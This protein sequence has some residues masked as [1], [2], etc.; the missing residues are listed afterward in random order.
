MCMADTSTMPSRILAS[1]TAVSTSAVM[2]MYSRF[3]WVSKVRYLVWA[4]MYCSRVPKG[5]VAARNLP[6]AGTPLKC[7]RSADW[8]TIRHNFSGAYMTQR[9]SVSGLFVLFAFC[10]LAAAQSPNWEIKDEALRT[11]FQA[12]V[13]A[14]ADRTSAE[15]RSITDWNA[16]RQRYRSELADMLGLDPMPEKTDLKAT[17]TGKL[18]H[19]DFTVEKLHFQSS[20]G[21]YVTANLYVPKKLD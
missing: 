3:L 12:E 4:F 20:P 15:L 11:Y 5:D 6:A 7:I 10:G 2:L 16:A 9:Q 21:L 19:A 14:S 8:V 13:S 18:E 17:V 1:R